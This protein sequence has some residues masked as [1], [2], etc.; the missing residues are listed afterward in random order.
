[1]HSRNSSRAGLSFTSLTGP[2]AQKRRH[3]PLRQIITTI[4]FLASCSVALL[5]V[6]TWSRLPASTTTAD[7]PSSAK[8]A[9]RL[10]SAA[11]GWATTTPAPVQPRRTQ[12]KDQASVPETLVDHQ[13]SPQP[14]QEQ[15]HERD[16]QLQPPVLQSPASTS[17]AAGD[18]AAVDDVL[19]AQYVTLCTA[20]QDTTVVLQKAAAA[21][22][23]HSAA[24]PAAPAQQQHA[25]AHRTAV[26]LSEE[27]LPRHLG[28]T[29]DAAAGDTAVSGMSGA[30]QRCP[31]VL[32]P[33]AAGDRSHGLCTDAGLYAQLLGAWLLPDTPAA[34]RRAAGCGGRSVL[35]F[36]EPLYDAWLEAADAA[37]PALAV[38]LAPN[39]EQL[40]V[41]DTAGVQR[42]QLVLCKVGRC[43]QLMRPFLAAINSSAVLLTTGV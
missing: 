9:A 7:G 2:A 42:A 33:L 24:A 32:L 34:R 31:P 18:C 17:A 41:S 10:R 28:V 43:T 38:V 3:R 15:Q 13:P 27:R 25:P 14:R 21:I 6:S 1:M 12:P 5:A 30:A 39:F 4:A 11:D 22:T 26:T 20:Q 36:L 23:A 40:S 29:G 19:L 35:L 37:S 8:Q 16:E